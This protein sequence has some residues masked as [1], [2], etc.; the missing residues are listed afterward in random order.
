MTRNSV[1]SLTKANQRYLEVLS[2]TKKPDS[3]DNTHSVVKSLLRA[4]AGGF[5]WRLLWAFRGDLQGVDK[6]V[7]ALLFVPLGIPAKW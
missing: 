2:H 4:F 7:S 6:R 1:H 3:F 5:M